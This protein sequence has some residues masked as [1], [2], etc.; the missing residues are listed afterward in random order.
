MLQK[1]KELNREHKGSSLYI[2]LDDPHFFSHSLSSVAE[3]FQKFGGKFLFLDEVHKYPS[4]HHGYDWSAEIKSL[5]DRY[6]DLY[7]IYS[8]SSSLKLYKGQG[9]LSRRRST[10]NLKGLSLREFIQYETGQQFCHNP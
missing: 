6:P 5:Y 1:V 8:G 10:Y 7:I 3:D 4:T 2:T 9:D